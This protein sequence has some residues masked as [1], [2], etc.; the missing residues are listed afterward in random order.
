MVK[1]RLLND[2]WAGDMEDFLIAGYEN[3]T[4][5]DEDVRN[6]KGCRRLGRTISRIEA[7]AAGTPNADMLMEY[8][9]AVESRSGYL[10]TA[11]YLRG[12]RRGFL[13]ARPHEPDGKDRQAAGRR[14]R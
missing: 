13:L 6:E 5:L 1:I 9:D 14:D 12:I 8:K 7:Q 11:A 3:V 10:H 4:D 2:E